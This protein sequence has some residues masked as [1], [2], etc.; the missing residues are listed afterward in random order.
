MSY[1]IN[2]LCCRFL[3]RLAYP[4]DLARFP[5]TWLVF[6]FF[7][8]FL[9]CTAPRVNTFSHTLQAEPL[10]LLISIFSFLTMLMYLKSPDFKHV[11]LLAVCPA[12]GYI[13]KQNLISWSWVMFVFLLLNN[14]KNFKHLALYAIAASAFICSAIGLCYL[15]WG[16][17][18][19]ETKGEAS[20][21]TIVGVL[22]LTIFVPKDSGSGALLALVD[23]M[24]D[25]VN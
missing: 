21:N 4:N 12:L 8:M 16:D 11:I 9:A 23:T 18:F 13:V 22:Q 7:A 14:P 2:G 5:N 6:T 10:A 20:E 17:A 25:A 15:L 24:R 3:N 1:K 19:I